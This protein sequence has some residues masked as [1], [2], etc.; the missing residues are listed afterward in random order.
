MLGK[1]I[2]TIIRGNTAINAII[3][4]RLYPISEME[5]GIPCV[6]YTCSTVPYYNKNSISSQLNEFSVKLYMYADYETAWNLAIMIKNAFEKSSRTTVAG[7]NIKRVYCKRI[8]DDHEFSID[9]FSPVVEF[10]ITTDDI[11]I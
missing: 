2:K 3:S 9:T 6:F 8:T 5:P 7:I 1:A 4:N 10:D 11:T